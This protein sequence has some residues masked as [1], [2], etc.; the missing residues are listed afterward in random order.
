MVV[1]LESRQTKHQVQ[2]LD[3]REWGVRCVGAGRPFTR[4]GSSLPMPG[5]SGLGAKVS[6]LY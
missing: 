1:E 4:L 5:G 3:L 6:W 2:G